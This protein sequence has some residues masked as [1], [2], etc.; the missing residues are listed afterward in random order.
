VEGTQ[1]KIMRSHFAAQSSR[2]LYTTIPN[3]VRAIKSRRV[4]WPGHVT[5]IGEKTGAYR[6]LM[7]RPEGRR[8]LGRPRR[9][10]EDNIEMDLQEV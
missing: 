9:R 3:I 5:R 2:L 6:I 7:G 1:C 4:R 8:P 10:W